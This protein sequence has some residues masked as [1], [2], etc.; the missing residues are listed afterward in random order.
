MDAIEVG[1]VTRLAE[2]VDPQR[3]GAVAGDPAE[4][5]E[6]RR[7]PVDDGDERGIRGESA[8]QSLDVR[9]RA[10]RSPG[11]GALRGRPAGVEAIGGGHGEQARP[12]AVLEDLRVGLARPRGAS[13]PAH[14]MAGSAVACSGGDDPVAAGQQ[15]APGESSPITRSG[16]AMGARRQPQV[17]RAAVGAPAGARSSSA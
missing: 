2:V 5:R 15:V 10:R 14:T 8:E 13:G 6:A 4:P 7:M 9:P 3:I 1:N 16:C 11:T 12:R 17:H